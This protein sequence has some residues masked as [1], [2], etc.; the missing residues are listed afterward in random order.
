MMSS[1]EKFMLR[2]QFVAMRRFGVRTERDIIAGVRQ[3]L[4]DHAEFGHRRGNGARHREVARDDLGH[5]VDNRRR[6]LALLA[7]RRVQFLLDHPVRDEARREPANERDQYETGRPDRLAQGC[8][9]HRPSDPSECYMRLGHSLRR[10]GTGPL[11]SSC[12]V[13]LAGRGQM[14]GSVCRRAAFRF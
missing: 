7:Q 8:P 6:H 12:A 10:A 9:F 2:Q 13:R 11:S 1:P 5:V 4:L 14:P 3:R